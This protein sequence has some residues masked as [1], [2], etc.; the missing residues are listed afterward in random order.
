MSLKMLTVSGVIDWVGPPSCPSRA[1]TK[2]RA[3]PSRNNIICAFK[4]VFLALKL[5]MLIIFYAPFIN[6]LYISLTF[7]ISSQASRFFAG[8]LN[9]KAG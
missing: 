2:A 5:L 9:R 8:L 4:K 7:F 3:I 1:G 6:V